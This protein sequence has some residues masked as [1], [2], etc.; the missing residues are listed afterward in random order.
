MT[1]YEFAIEEYD[2]DYRA[3]VTTHYLKFPSWEEAQQYCD[4]NNKQRNGSYL[5]VKWGMVGRAICSTEASFNMKKEN[6]E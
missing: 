5:L 2:T 3:Y 6:L 4:D 1:E